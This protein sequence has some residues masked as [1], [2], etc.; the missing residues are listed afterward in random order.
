MI[1]IIYT[2][3][4][5]LLPVFLSAENNLETLIK[6]K[7]CNWYDLPKE[8]RAFGVD[9]KIVYKI[10]MKNISEL[11]NE[12]PYLLSDVI[13][14]HLEEY[15]GIK[16]SDIKKYLNSEKQFILYDYQP[17]MERKS[18]KKIEMNNEVVGETSFCIQSENLEVGSVF[19]YHIYF[20][21][22]N[23]IYQFWMEYRCKETE[24][25]A[26]SKMVDIFSYENDCL[27]W[28]DANSRYEF[29]QLLNQKNK[30]IPDSLLN[31]Q[32]L[33]DNIRS[34]LKIY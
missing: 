11:S 10:G 28:K 3:I 31:Y 9:S 20:I 30:Q 1:K 13:K 24:K 23:Y 27:Y 17:T 4:L 8:E 34:N 16:E 33:Y 21:D 32:K 29:F 12:R 15:K 18:Y 2:F 22:G 19:V 25:L 7:A 14:K 26:L 5:L 6:D